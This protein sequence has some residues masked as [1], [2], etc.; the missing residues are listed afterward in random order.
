M[1]PGNRLYLYQL[2]STKVGIGRQV[3][4][5]QVEELLDTDG[6]D[7]MGLGYEG[8]RELVEELDDFMRLTVF[9]KGRVYATVTAHEAFDAILARLNESAATSGK[10]AGEGAATTAGKP[11]GAKT[12]KHRKSNKDPKPAK[13]R[14]RIRREARRKSDPD[15]EAVV[16]AASGAIGG[17]AEEPTPSPEPELGPEP[18]V[19]PEPEPKPEGDDR[20]A[21]DHVSTEG[22][23]SINI[24]YNPYDY[25]ELYLE[26]EGLVTESV[27]AQSEQGGTGGADPV[28]CTTE[29][30]AHAAKDPPP[31][32]PTGGAATRQRYELFRSFSHDVWCKDEPLSLLYQVLPYDIE[33]MSV[34]EDDWRYARST[35]T[36]EGTHSSIRFPLSFRASG[37]ERPIV[38]Q[39]HRSVKLHAGKAWALEA[40]DLGDVGDAALQ[41][42]A[43]P[44]VGSDTRPNRTTQLER[45]L[46]KLFIIGSWES[47][48]GELA[49]LAAKERWG[50]RDTLGLTT[51]GLAA[52]G[53][54]IPPELSILC[55]YLALTLHR[56]REKG[57]LLV[58]RDGQ[59][60]A[61]NTGLLSI[62]A[63]AI[64]DV[65]LSNE[66]DIRWRHAG[67]CTASSGE[68]GTLLSHSLNEPPRAASYLTSLDEVT[69][70]PR[71][72]VELGEEVRSQL[73]D[74][75]DDIVEKSV[76]RVRSSYRLLVPAYDPAPSTHV[77]GSEGGDVVSLLP[78]W[79]EDPTQPKEP[80]E[81]KE[82]LLLR[83]AKVKRTPDETDG[84]AS[85]VDGTAD[86]PDA[87]HGL[88][89]V[90]GL[91]ASPR[92]V[93]EELLPPA[94]AYSRARAICADLPSWLTSSLDG[95]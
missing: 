24:T 30:S 27:E 78:L 68:L 52:P 50:A 38:A 69:L 1:T 4:L 62:G 59:L 11:T 33:P 94:Q 21:K 25:G 18:Q 87:V 2:L 76:R 71:A 39:L 14:V 91:D 6:I 54:E 36:Y 45:D 82:A 73:G 93:A 47:Y 55:E 37:S 75:A 80:G 44:L 84:M 22:H 86:G 77:S 13:P 17:D 85:G 63:E 5:S 31:A 35:S 12:W 26:D 43:L 64:F 19:E 81:P 88:N 58:S 74:S 83:R 90:H 53:G 34:L 3:P 92:Y 16:E 57:Q 48:L 15:P 61:F 56:V 49:N 89:A 42:E 32:A 72:H 7:V 29:D 23:I 67:F 40:I 79:G 66:S 46:A 51:S 70:R 8:V 95:G 28:S 20:R 9:K 60:A 65:L 41:E 10:D